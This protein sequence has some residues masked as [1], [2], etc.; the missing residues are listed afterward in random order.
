MNNSKL[1]AGILA[2]SLACLGNNAYCEQDNTQGMMQKLLE[3][4]QAATAKQNEQAIHIPAPLPRQ[5]TNPNEN[6]NVYFGDTHVHTALSF[7]SYLSG[8]RMGIREAY[9]FANG[10]AVTRSS[11]E[12]QQLHQPLDFVVLTDHSESFGLFRT[13]DLPGLTPRQSEFCQEMTNN[14]EK[15]YLGTIADRMKRPPQRYT[16]LCN[17]NMQACLAESEN[18]WQ[19]I[20]RTADEFNKPGEFTAFS[21]YEY[22]PPLPKKGKLHRN[23]IFKGSSVPD[24]AISAFDALT[25]LDLW[26]TLEAQCTGDCEFL[27]IPHNMNKTWGLAY[28]G[29]TIDGDPYSKDDWAL[30]KRNEPIAEIYQIKGSSECGLDV[31]AADEECNFERLLPICETQVAGCSGPT[32]F[33]R[34]GLKTGLELEQELGFNPLQFGF[35]GST[36]THAGTPGD[37][38]EYD[39][40]GMAGLVDSPASMRLGYNPSRQI[41]K[42]IADSLRMSP[43][44]LAAVW[45]KENT[46]EAI[47]EAMERRE[48]YATSG[49]RIKLRFF[50]GWNYDAELIHDPDLLSKAYRN[51]VPMGGILPAAGKN[52]VPEFLVW[53]ARDSNGGKLQRVQLVKAW[54]EDGK[55]YE[56]VFDIGC[57]DG[58]KPD[59]K[60]GRCPDNG[61]RVDIAS[62][63]VS[64]DKGDSEIRVSWRDPDFKPEQSAFYYVR[65]LENPS[66]RW[67]SYDAI[68]LGITPREGVPATIQERAWSSP[69]WYTP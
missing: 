60:T 55:T 11:G 12:I 23:V 49:N 57:S 45:A 16:A 46:R 39:Y 13:C 6:N 8:N 41:G 1:A 26:T 24:R 53:A 29:T 42:K 9:R 17:D 48:T 58:L 47:F 30:R 3:A 50:A 65:V 22:S 69:I 20:H 56:Q 51:G 36:D 15:L 63:A 62:C 4:A 10:E 19:L 31:G 7:D 21:G 67:S 25:V 59:A 2:V 64:A 14:P 54:L 43:G 35:I 66:C 27:T 5:K 33:A 52:T 32:S 18:T 40:R 38:E 61:A 37:T 28:S 44:G 34:E 68:R